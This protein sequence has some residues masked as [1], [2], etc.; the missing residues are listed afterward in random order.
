M[1]LPEDTYSLLVVGRHPLTIGIAVAVMTVQLFIV[2][3]LMADL[4]QRNSED[5]YTPYNP[6]NI[7]AAVTGP[8]ATAQF[9]AVLVTLVSV[10]N[11]TWALLVHWQ[12]G[13]FQDPARFGYHQWMTLRPRYHRED[14]EREPLNPDKDE[15]S[16]LSSPL[17]NN[18]EDES[19]VNSAVSLS[20][21]HAKGTSPTV[22]KWFAVIWYGSNGRRSLEGCSSFVGTFLLIVTS[23][24]VVDVLLTFSAIHFVSYLDNVVFWLACVGYFGR[25]VQ[26]EALHPMCC[27]ANFTTIPA[28]MQPMI[29][30]HRQRERSG[31]DHTKTND[32][33]VTRSSLEEKN[34]TG[35]IC[36]PNCL[37]CDCHHCL[38]DSAGQTE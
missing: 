27:S 23:E 7:P 22:S 8:V 25:T 35:R 34:E 14:E 26:T 1:W 11:M 3:I 18:K 15:E 28:L 32:S 16:A 6:L 13:H 19:S 2:T 24:T 21:T 38:V 12:N 20:V 36:A 5:D 10:D 4:I 29:Q 30:R 33:D 17:Q 37:G 31:K 9:I